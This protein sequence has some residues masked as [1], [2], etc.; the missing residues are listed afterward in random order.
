AIILGASRVS[1]CEQTRRTSFSVPTPPALASI[2][3]QS[4]EAGPLLPQR[5][6]SDVPD[7]SGLTAPEIYLGSSPPLVASAGDGIV[8]VGSEE[9]TMNFANADVREVLNEVLGNALGL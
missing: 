9:V 1:G 8:D 3:G 6:T 4:Q 2:S 7:S 5:T